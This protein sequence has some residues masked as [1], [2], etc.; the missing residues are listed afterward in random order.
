MILTVIYLFC[1]LMVFV[2]GMKVVKLGLSQSI[3]DHNKFVLN[4]LTGT[5]LSSIFLGIIITILMQSSSATIVLVISLVNVNLI[6]L[7]QALGMVIGANIG[8]TITGQI[9]S[10]SLENYFWI[11]FVVGFGL[12]LF[13]KKD[14]N[15][16]KNKSKRYIALAEAAGGFGLI[17]AGLMLMTNSLVPLAETKTFLDLI[18]KLSHSSIKAFISG[19]I[20]T[21]MLQSSSTFIGVILTLARQNLVNLSTAILL[22]LGSNIG[23]C[24]TAVIAAINGTKTAKLVAQGHIIF[25]LGGALIFLPFVSLYSN[26]IHLTSHN[27]VRQ[28]ANGHTIFNIINAF[29]FYLIFDKFAQLIRRLS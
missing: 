18:Y 23:T 27:L 10:F 12:Y 24:I 13:G 4:Y 5:K 15:K 19:I 8:T 9:I 3:N 2:Y 22:L 7:N 25:N 6:G 11:F 29:L 20:G 21:A 16:N 14:K 1:G 17:F 26:M 28:I